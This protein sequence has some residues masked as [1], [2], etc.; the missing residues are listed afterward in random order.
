METGI[1]LKSLMWHDMACPLCAHVT[2]M[3]EEDCERYIQE[4]ICCLDCGKKTTL[5]YANLVLTRSVLANSVEEA[6]P[7]AKVRQSTGMTPDR[8]PVDTS[9][10]HSLSSG[11]VH[12]PGRNQELSAERH[13]NESRGRLTDSVGNVPAISD[14]LPASNDSTGLESANSENDDAIQKPLEPLGLPL[15]TSC[16]PSVDEDTSESRRWWL[17]IPACFAENERLAAGVMASFIFHGLFLI[18]LA[19]IIIHIPVDGGFTILCQMN[20]AVDQHPALKFEPQERDP[21][22]ETDNT[23]NEVPKEEDVTK[24]LLA[25]KTQF[26][27]DLLNVLF[28]KSKK[29]PSKSNKAD[30]TEGEPVDNRPAQ[31]KAAFAGRN[32]KIRGAFAK[33]NGATRESEAAVE[34]GLEWLARHQRVNGSWTFMHKTTECT[35]TCEGIGHTHC[36]TAATGFA[37]LCFLGAGYTHVEGKHAETVR[38]GLEYLKQQEHGDQR[39]S[40]DDR[41]RGPRDG[42][43]AQ[44]I[45]TLALCEAYGMTRDRTLHRY[46]KDAIQFI[47]DAQ[48]PIGG[49]WRYYPQSRGDLSVTGWHIMAVVSAEMAGVSVPTKTKEQAMR[50]LDSVENK[51]NGAYGYTGPATKISTTA[52]GLLCRLYLGWKINNRQLLKGAKLLSRPSATDMY[53][54]YYATQVMLHLGSN[55]WVRWNRLMREHLVK[56]Q[57]QIGHGAGSWSPTPDR[58]GRSGGR[59]YVTC[60]S[61]MTLEVYYRH[62]PLY[63]DGALDMP[64]LNKPSQ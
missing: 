5:R 27:A 31:F 7:T 41:I 1:N 32:K 48:D 14:A 40:K 25:E 47:V 28:P 52:I 17:L 13:A 11:F 20:D 24:N 43:Y 44:G 9:K 16:E 37:L 53:S 54:N 4:E 45:A 46:A 61:I 49:G 6:S 59:H 38:A 63:Q 57:Y 58:Y 18:V 55:R 19:L 51:K 39:H 64:N 3:V 26:D 12:S 56:N 2:T 34:L 15:V 8:S 21:L 30:A 36:R 60:L 42:M 33:L 23:E 62:L 35:R 50:Y 22:D 10:K 29:V